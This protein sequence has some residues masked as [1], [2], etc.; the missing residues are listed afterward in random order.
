MHGLDSCDEDS[1]APK[2]LES[3]H[4]ACDSF[5]RPVVLLDQV[6]EIFVLA[7]Q[8]ADTGF[9]LDTFNGRRVGAALVDGDFLGQAVQVD[10]SLQEAPSSG[11]IPLCGEKVDG[12]PSAINPTVKVLPLARDFDVGLIHSSTPTNETFAPAKDCRH[13]QQNFDRPAV[14]GVVVNENAALLHHF[15]HTAQAQ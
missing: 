10:G 7:H 3:E 9:I 1:S 14:H 15:L 2:R 12:V 4:R 11:L 5:N 6:V 13:H 8:E